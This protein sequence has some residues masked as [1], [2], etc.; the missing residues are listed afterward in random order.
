MPSKSGTRGNGRFATGTTLGLV[1]TNN[2]DRC[3]I[4]KARFGDTP[5]RDFNVGVVCDGLGGMEGG[6][7]AASL[8][9]AVFLT[10][11]VQST[12]PSPTDRLIDAVTA[13][14]ENIYSMLRGRGGTTLTAVIITRHHGSYFCHVGD[15]RLFSI[16]PDR[17][18]QQVTRDDTL[19]ALLQKTPLENRSDSRLLQFVG[20]GEEMEPQIEPLGLDQ[21]SSFLLTS[22]G[23]HDVPR[24][25]LERVISTASSPLDLSRKLIQL[26]EM[27][28][29]FDNATV[30]VMPSRVEDEPARPE[31]TELSIMVPA[32]E[33]AIWLMPLHENVPSAP[34]GIRNE[35]KSATASTRPPAPPKKGSSRAEKSKKTATPSKARAA[36]LSKKNP[37]ETQL[38]LE[39]KNHEVNVEFQ[40]DRRGQE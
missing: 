36:K 32:E 37:P 33:V 22:D 28:G 19:A 24:P 30:V 15:T 13:A 9:L 3:A 26:S 5:N 16:G 34:A 21:R 29:G 27:I 7:E 1:R 23:A 6:Q 25:I 12:R 38:P 4:V 10:T 35:T 14:N 17:V 39:A 40:S 18:V 11:L 8:G 31:A 20:M 2:E